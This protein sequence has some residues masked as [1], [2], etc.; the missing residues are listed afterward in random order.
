VR[1]VHQSVADARL[2]FQSN[3][4][5]AETRAL[6]ISGSRT[7]MSATNGEVA[8]QENFRVGAGQTRHFATRH[9]V[10]PSLWIRLAEPCTRNEWRFESIGLCSN[11]PWAGLN[12]LVW[13]RSLDVINDEDVDW[14]FGRFQFQSELFL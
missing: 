12:R 6:L 14:T 13:G 3:G 10:Y 7:P 4:H 2:E 1:I 8:T 11:S 5:L 9:D